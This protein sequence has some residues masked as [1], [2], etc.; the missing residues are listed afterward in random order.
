MKK[1]FLAFLIYFTA[2]PSHAFLDK[3]DKAS[4]K[5]D[6][7]NDSWGGVD[8]VFERKSRNERKSRRHVP[9][10]PQY[11]ST[12]EKISG[13][14]DGRTQKGKKNKIDRSTQIYV[15]KQL[16][17]DGF[18]QGNENL[19]KERL[20]SWQREREAELREREARI[21]ARERELGISD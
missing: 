6:R 7:V 3:I 14:I 8:R 13:V 10:M 12:E 11:E 18:E 5:A 1:M 20:A 2:I 16:Q 17:N 21:K 19:K 15:E 4:K 9:G